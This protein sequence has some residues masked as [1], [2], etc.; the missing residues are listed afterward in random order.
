MESDRAVWAGGD[1]PGYR[2]AVLAN[3]AASVRVYFFPLFGLVSVWRAPRPRFAV[4]LATFAVGYAISFGLEL[5]DMKWW[6]SRF[7]APGIALALLWGFVA[8]A[9]LASRPGQR[10]ARLALALVLVVGSVGPARELAWT[11]RQNFVRVRHVDPM[12]QRLRLLLQAHP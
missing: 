1:D 9:T 3:L 8:A 5:S 4:A 11:F 12:D 2:A 10:V 6:L 7:L